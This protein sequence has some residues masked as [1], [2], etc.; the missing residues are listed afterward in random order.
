[1]RACRGEAH[2]DLLRECTELRAPLAH[3]PGGL[4]ERLA[5]S[6]ARPRPREAISSPTRSS[7][8][9]EP[10]TAC[11]S[12]SNRLASPSVSGS[13]IANSSSTATVR[14]VPHS[15]RCARG[16]AV[17]PGSGVRV[18]HRAE[19]YFENGSSR[20]S[21]I[22]VQLQSASTA[23]RAAS[24]RSRRVSRGSASSSRSFAASSAALPFSKAARCAQCPE[25][26]RPRSRPRPRR[27]PS[28]ARRSADTPRGGLGGDHA[29]RLGEDRG[30]HG[31]VGERQQMHEVSVLERAG[32][33]RPRRRGGLELSPGSRRSPRSPHGHRPPAAPRG[34]CARPCSRSACRSRG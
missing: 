7:S 22:R 19:A 33:E 10:T 20:R 32:E 9:S 24:P 17:P 30:H 25:G 15:M 8:S 12:S 28:G 21:A 2:A 23:P 29:K 14:S 26:T 27:G 1:M 3:L 16:G 5:S 31:N 18:A 34:G 4:G 6:R 11:W 13:R